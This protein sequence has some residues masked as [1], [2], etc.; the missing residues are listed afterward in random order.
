MKP[1]VVFKGVPNGKIEKELESYPKN[2][3]Y[4]VQ[5]NAW[6]DDRIMEKYMDEVLFTSEEWKE[7]PNPVILLDD[8]GS[9]KSEG[10]LGKLRSNGAHWIGIPPGCTSVCQ[11][12]DVVIMK[13]FKE[14]M[15]ES[16]E[17]TVLDTALFRA[18]AIDSERKEEV[19]VAA[20]LDEEDDV[21]N[22]VIAE[23][24]VVD[25]AEILESLDTRFDGQTR[26]ST[27]EK[28]MEI[29]SRVAIC[30]NDVS[31][32]H[33]VKAFIAASD[34]RDFFSYI[35][36]DD[37]KVPGY[38][39][40]KALLEASLQEVEVVETHRNVL[41]HF[42]EINRTTMSL[43]G[44][45]AN[46]RKNEAVVSKGVMNTK[47]G[48]PSGRRCMFQNC[49]KWNRTSGFCQSHYKE[50]QVVRSSSNWEML[51]NLNR[52]TKSLV[53]GC[54][55]DQIANINN[56]IVKRRDYLALY[57]YDGWLTDEVMNGMFQIMSTY[58]ADSSDLFFNTFYL[59]R[60]T[61]S[62]FSSQSGRTVM[63]SQRIL[64]PVHLNGN[65]WAL[66]VLVIDS[67]KGNAMWFDSGTTVSWKLILLTLCDK[68]EQARVERGFPV[69]TWTFEFMQSKKQKDGL[70]CGVFTIM[71]AISLI[72]GKDF[73]VLQNDIP[74][75]RRR[76][77]VC[78][79]ESSLEPIIDGF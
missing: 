11:P 9:H 30:W 55:E 49:L 1:F 64:T 20:E 52:K 7:S 67:G 36:E 47:N 79:L 60:G 4:A 39:S 77:C 57:Q 33:C 48:P 35:P 21:E 26:L 14:K 23:G 24:D 65:H 41:R 37:D 8:L 6:T 19:D 5:Q 58:Q 66:A 76:L 38:D 12:L 31:S 69:V 17:H 46:D 25:D 16:C 10:T 56:V 53:E 3:V 50:M 43:N 68:V 44:Q 2:C 34:E 13:L 15:R 27:K 42:G 72:L 45:S 28:R 51:G 62:W 40:W 22:Y 78:I 32:V 70:S 54:P 61:P 74:F 71:H 18:L 73:A 29:A 63:S 59:Q 75:I